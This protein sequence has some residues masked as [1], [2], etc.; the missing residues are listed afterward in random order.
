MANLYTGENTR[1]IVSL[2]SLVVAHTKVR[3]IKT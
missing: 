2:F 1:V 3:K